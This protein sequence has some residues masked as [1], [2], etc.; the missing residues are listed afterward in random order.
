LVGRVAN[1]IE[2]FFIELSAKEAAKL[3]PFP[4]AFRQMQRTPA[5]PSRLLK[6]DT[7]HGY[8]QRYIELIL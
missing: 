1:I 7:W 4:R 5:I 8:C 3:P 2:R 6:D